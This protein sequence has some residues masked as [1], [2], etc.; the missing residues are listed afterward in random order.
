MWLQMHSGSRR[1]PFFTADIWYETTG[2]AQVCLRRLA[3]PGVERAV[4]V[5]N[6]MELGHRCFSK[7]F[8]PW[9]PKMSAD[10]ELVMRRGTQT[11][12]TK[13]LNP[14]CSSD[15]LIPGPVPPHDSQREHQHLQLCLLCLQAKRLQHLLLKLPFQPASHVSSPPVQILWPPPCHL[16]N[17][18][19]IQRTESSSVPVLIIRNILKRSVNTMLLLFSNCSFFCFHRC[20]CKGFVFLLQPK[21]VCCWRRPGWFLHGA[22]FAQG[23]SPFSDVTTRGW[24][25]G[26]CHS[27]QF[28]HS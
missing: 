1:R 19:I 12:S 18:D 4:L 28:S 14:I 21:G 26:V 24:L 3:F 8:L 22:A 2:A 25:I 20:R 7:F 23:T 17:V 27:D 15:F 9:C 16:N 5:R 11:L 10:T 6:L 13:H